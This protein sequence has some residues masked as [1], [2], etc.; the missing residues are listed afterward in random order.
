MFAMWLE[1]GRMLSWSSMTTQFLQDAS[2][3]MN[4]E[5]VKKKING[6]V[7]FFCSTDSNAKPDAYLPLIEPSHHILMSLSPVSRVHVL[8]ENKPR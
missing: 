8:D 3:R 2:D 5:I 1:T 4:L 7:N 6:T